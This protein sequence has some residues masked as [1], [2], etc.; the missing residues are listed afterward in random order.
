[1]AVIYV[2]AIAVIQRLPHIVKHS[3]VL[4]PNSDEELNM[5]I[6]SPNH[7]MKICQYYLQCSVLVTLAVAGV[8]FEIPLALIRHLLFVLQSIIFVKWLAPS[9]MNVP[10]VR[11]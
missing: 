3:T 1:M 6:A 4:I 5:V 11:P 8:G 10:D 2:V 7:L 9:T